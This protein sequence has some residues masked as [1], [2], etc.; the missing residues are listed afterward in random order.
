MF[1][2]LYYWM[3]ITLKKKNPNDMSEI[4]A[5]FLICIL[6]IFNIATIVIVIRYF[7]NINIGIERNIGGYLGLGFAFV[8]AIINRFVLYRKREIFFKKYENMPIKRQK[9]GQIYFWIYVVLS[10][11]IVFTA[12][13]NLIPMK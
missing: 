9:K 13:I 11:V 6:Q 3:Y 1:R 5:Y 12:G 2:E 10:V 8:L 4:N 7:L